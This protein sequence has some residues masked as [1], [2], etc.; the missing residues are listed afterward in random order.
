MCQLPNWSNGPS[1]NG[2]P[3]DGWLCERPHDDPREPH[4]RVSFEH[5]VVNWPVLTVDDY[6]RVA[7]YLLEHEEFDKVFND[8][9]IESYVCGIVIGL[10]QAGR[11]EKY[12][13]R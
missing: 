1:Y 9:Q 3:P 6:D 2:G 5:G 7:R 11:W 4:Y 12:G 13:T 8:L 10:Q